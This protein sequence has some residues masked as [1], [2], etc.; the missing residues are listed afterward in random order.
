MPKAAIATQRNH[1]RASLARS[2]ACVA[3]TLASLFLAATGRAQVPPPGTG[4]AALYEAAKA[5]GKIVF[6]SSSPLE[7]TLA[8][9]RRFE[10][11][12]PGVK[13]EVSRLAG[14]QQY[15]RFMQEAEANRNVA[16]VVSNSDRP[17]MQ[18]LIADGH[19]AAWRVPTFDRF[20]P[21]FR[22]GEHAISNALTNLVIVYNSTKVTPDEAK[23]L[24]SS[25]GAVLDPR[26][27]GRL[28]VTNMLCGACYSGIQLFMDPKFRDEWG[29]AFLRKVAA[30]RPAVYPDVVV[31]LD[32]VVAGEQDVNFWS[33]EAAATIKWQQGA[34]IRWVHPNPTPVLG[35]SWIGVS[36]H[37]P[38]PN[39]GRLFQN[40][41]MS[42]EG[43]QALQLDYGT[44]TTMTGT[45]DVRPVT[46]EPWWRP[47]EQSYPIDFDRWTREFTRDMNLWVRILRNAR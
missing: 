38:H 35:L 43:M 27:R 10:Q 31:A 33:W 47:V 12:Y 26:F 16:D 2:L 9:A 18:Q 41:F 34:P 46:K 25:W 32:R 3:G 20:P 15:Q 13:V 6:Y 30:Q 21:E 7:G 37:A 19:I 29:E 44:P 36:A 23:L 45:P 40:W 24:E 17:S 42:E 1:R 28:S 11:R 5:E 39:A 8:L 14:V 4:E 22:I